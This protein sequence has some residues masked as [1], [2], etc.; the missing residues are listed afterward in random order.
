M[1]NV[2]IAS[3]LPEAKIRMIL[4]LTSTGY[5]CKQVQTATKIREQIRKH[6]FDLLFTEIDLLEKLG[7]RDTINEIFKKVKTENPLCRIVVLGNTNQLRA[8]VGLI[9]SGAD[10]YLTLPMDEDE[11]RIVLANANEQIIQHAELNYLRDKFW[12]INSPDTVKTSS[13]LMASVL[14]KIYSVAPTRATVLLCGETG[15]GKGVIAQLL[16][17]QSNRS[18]KSFISVHCGAIPDTLLESELFGHEKGAFTGAIRKKLGKFE[19]AANGTLFLDEVG[20]MTPAAQ[21]KLLQVLQENTF[22]RVGGEGNITT[23][24]RIIVATNMDLEAMVKDGRFRKDLFYRLNVF[25]IEIPPLRKRTEDIPS[26]TQLFLNRFNEK[27][28]KRINAIHPIILT[29]LQR[30]DWPGNVRELENL[31]ERAHILTPGDTLVPLNFPPE[32]IGG[33]QQIELPAVIGDS[34][35]AEARQVVIASFEEQ[36]LRQILTKHHGRINTSAKAAGIGVRQFHKLMQKYNIRK[37][38]F[39]PK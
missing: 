14:K 17:Q 37:E 15:T 8:I 38:T 2:L 19:L 24:A 28:Q 10:D 34:T 35:L 29:A 36:Y 13:P 39:F 7:G 32:V 33:T 21:I 11:V 26:L 20:T 16:H 27:Y 31:V 23:H 25:P 4:N 22:S 5:R 6:G 12:N 9:Q 30:Y 1:K 18:R 3:E